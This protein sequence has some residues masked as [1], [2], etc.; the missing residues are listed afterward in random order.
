M[1]VNQ[2]HIPWTGRP[3]LHYKSFYTERLNS[4]AHLRLISRFTL[5]LAE[6]RTLV[7]LTERWQPQPT[8]MLSVLTLSHLWCDSF[9]SGYPISDT[10]SV[11]SGTILLSIPSIPAFSVTVEEGQP[12]HEPCRIT[13]TIP[14][15]KDLNSMFPPSISTAGFT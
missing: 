12:L 3:S 15:S 1:V 13:V 9:G 14:L 6:P 5:F 2:R 10:T 7:H 11:T 4:L 8:V